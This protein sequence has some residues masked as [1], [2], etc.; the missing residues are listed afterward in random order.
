VPAICRT[1]ATTIRDGQKNIGFDIVQGERQLVRDCIKLW[2]FTVEGIEQA[3]RGIPKIVIE[4]ELNEDGILHVKAKDWKRDAT[5]T[6]WI[7]NK[8]NLWMEPVDKLL[9]GA[10]AEKRRDPELRA[11][12]EAMSELGIFLYRAKIAFDAEVH[13]SKQKSAEQEKCRH[14]KAT[15]RDWQETH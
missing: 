11:K 10:E 1:T 13:K 8:G 5:M 14:A 9:A 2:H 15:C 3:K 6:G 4:M 7:E 12:A